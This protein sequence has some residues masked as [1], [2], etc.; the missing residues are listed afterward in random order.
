MVCFRKNAWGR[1]VVAAVGGASPGPSSAL[2]I[3]VAGEEERP[4]GRL[5]APSSR[6][7]HTVPCREPRREGLIPTFLGCC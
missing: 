3:P 6:P 2:V 1:Q 4:M 7:F 5:Y